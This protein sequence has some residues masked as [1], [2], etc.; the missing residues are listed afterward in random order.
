MPSMQTNVAPEFRKTTET[1]KAAAKTLPQ[2]YFISPEIF[3]E[4]QESIFSKQWVLVGHQSQIPQGGDYLP[5]EV[6]GESLILFREKPAAINGFYNRAPTRGGRL[7]E[8]R[9]EQSPP[10]Q[11]PNTA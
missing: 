10:I 4:E 3:A 9:H 7:I 1:F 6:A 2:R 8:K 5:T 11:C